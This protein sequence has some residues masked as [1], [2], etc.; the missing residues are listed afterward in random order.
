MNEFGVKWSSDQN[1]L[2]K[3]FVDNVSQSI[4]HMNQYD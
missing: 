1:A 4:A 2:I 3:A